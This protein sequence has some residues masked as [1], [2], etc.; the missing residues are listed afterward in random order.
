MN[1]YGYLRINLYL[2]G[3][4]FRK[5]IYHLVLETFVGSCPQGMEA[6][7]NNGDATDNRLENLRWDTRQNNIADRGIHGHTV[8]GEKV[9]TS[10]LKNHNIPMIRELLN[11][12]RLSERGIGEK[13]G[14]TQQAVSLIKLNKRFSQIPALPPQ[15]N[16]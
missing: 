13:F 6:C 8:S 5:K 12:G 9:G 4:R 3:R 2:N 1:K 15:L 16:H 11:E 7:H 10:K 14:V